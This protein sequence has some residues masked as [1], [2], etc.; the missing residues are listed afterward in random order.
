MEI[1]ILSAKRTPI[2]SFQGSLAGHSVVD[3]WQVIASWN[4][5]AMLSQPRLKILESPL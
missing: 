2:G 4:S 3:L 5:G 1:F